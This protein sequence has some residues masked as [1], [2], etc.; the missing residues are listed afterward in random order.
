MSRSNYG[1]NCQL[2]LGKEGLKQ[3]S[4]AVW[5]VPT[6]SVQGHSYSRT[7]SPEMC[8]SHNPGIFFCPWLCKPH[9]VY[10]ASSTF[11]HFW[12]S[13]IDL[14]TAKNGLLPSHVRQANSKMC[15]SSWERRRRERKRILF[16]RE[17]SREKRGKI[18][19]GKDLFLRHG[20]SS[21]H[22]LLTC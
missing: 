7:S 14:G 4:C 8:P 1:N 12:S 10:C 15:F 17:H 16:G 2:D 3:M 5:L 11:E 18:R 20:V 21:Y 13:I 19:Q 6:C 22:C 9:W